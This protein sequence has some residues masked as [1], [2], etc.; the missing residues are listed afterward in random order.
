MRVEDATNHGRL[1]MA[2]LFEDRCYLFEFK[3]VEGEAEG[4][5]LE[6]LKEKRYFEKYTAECHKIFLIG[7]ELSKRERNIVSFE[8]EE[9][10]N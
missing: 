1:D 4:R 10:K 5:A 3:V 9:L 6:Q 8:V 2:V 7:V